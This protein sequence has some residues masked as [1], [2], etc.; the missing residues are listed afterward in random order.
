MMICM[1]SL[2]YSRTVIQIFHDDFLMSVV[3][4]GGDGTIPRLSDEI[5]LERLSFQNEDRGAPV[6]FGVDARIARGE[7]IGI[8][9][10]SGSGKST[11]VDLLL[12]VVVPTADRILVDG[13]DVTSEV[14]SWQR[15]IGYVPQGSTCSTTPSPA[16]SHSEPRS[17]HRCW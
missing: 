12:G 2:T 3:D 16:T 17:M 4:E 15:Q 5:R 8:I 1:Q 14:G 7:K 9:G 11:L 6:P 10:A 13:A